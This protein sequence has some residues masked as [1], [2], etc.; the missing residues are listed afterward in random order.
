M[1]QIGWSY[2]E[3]ASVTRFKIRSHFLWQVTTFQTALNQ[4]HL[5][6]QGLFIDVGLT[7]DVIT[8]GASFAKC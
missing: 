8:S 3:N 6:R 4:G 1:M 7:R 2:L 5:E